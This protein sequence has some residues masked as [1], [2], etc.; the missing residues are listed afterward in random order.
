MA[1][2]KQQQKE[3]VDEEFANED[4]FA[5]TGNEMEYFEFGFNDPL[6]EDQVILE[7]I[8]T[9]FLGTNDF[10]SK[11]FSTIIA[12]QA[13][14]GSC[15]K[16]MN[17]DEVQ[18]DA[19]GISSVVSLKFH[20]GKWKADLA[21]LLSKAAAPAIPDN[22]HWGVLVSR[23]AVGIPDTV[24]RPLYDSLQQDLEYSRTEYAEDAAMY[25]YDKI[26][27]VGQ[28]AIKVGDHGKR[29]NATGDGDVLYAQTEDSVI[30]PQCCWSGHVVTGHADEHEYRT[31]VGLLEMDKYT[32]VLGM[33]AQLFAA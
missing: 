27:V 32:A 33:I 17:G 30:I 16:V 14:V 18:S 25:T 29:A 8:L 13:E 11:G 2:R 15:V 6:P 10:D 5:Q 19:L 21:A 4:I 26:I 1:K 24:V 28:S 23:R 3:V 7:G 31:H 22:E 9:G 20:D 12:N